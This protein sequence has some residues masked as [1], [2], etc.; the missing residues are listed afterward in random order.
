MFTRSRL[1]KNRKLCHARS[2]TESCQS[3]AQH[4]HT[5]THWRFPIGVHSCAGRY[6]G[7]LAG[8]R[9]R[10]L[11]RARWTWVRRPKRSAGQESCGQFMGLR[12]KSLLHCACCSFA[13]RCATCPSVCGN[14]DEHRLGLLEA[15]LRRTLLVFRARQPQKMH[16]AVGFSNAA[17]QSGSP[18]HGSTY[19]ALVPALASRL[20]GQGPQGGIP[21]VLPSA[22]T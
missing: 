10:D 13:L 1:S 2:A 9:S 14:T 22:L 21:T 19:A 6:S 15:L 8:S 11:R 7:R 4:C 12:H 18:D 5:R 20:H 17:G 16:G 3:F